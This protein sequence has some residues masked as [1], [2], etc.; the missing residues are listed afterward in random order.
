VATEEATGGVAVAMEAKEG[1]GWQVVMIR[2]VV[3]P[4]L[5]VLR[6]G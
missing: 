5:S 3:L 1:M 2:V 6:M 4:V